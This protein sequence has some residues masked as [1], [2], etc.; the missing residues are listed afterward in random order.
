MK[1][2]LITPT[3]CLAILA[4]TAAVSASAS[5]DRAGTWTPIELQ[6]PVPAPGIGGYLINDGSFELGPPPASAWTEVSD[7]PCERI[8]D[9]SGIWYVSAFDGTQDYWAGGYCDGGSGN[10]PVTSSVTQTITMPPNATFWLNFTYIALRPDAD[11]AP[12][13]GDRAYV[14][15]NGVEVWSLPLVRANDTYPDWSELVVIDMSAYRDQ[16]VSLSFGGVSVG[17]VTGNLRFDYIGIIADLGPVEPSTW[18]ALKALY[19]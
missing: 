18:G 17:D 8:G 4:I 10:V 15:V 5:L 16:K 14:T 1:L 7:P 2:L 3:S 13:D 11:D 9:F 12:D 6:P 19:R